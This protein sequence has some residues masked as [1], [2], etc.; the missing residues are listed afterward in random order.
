MTQREKDL[1]YEVLELL[2]KEVRA[3]SDFRNRDWKDADDY[4][5]SALHLT[6]GDIAEIYSGRRGLVYDKSAIEGF[7]PV[8]PSYAELLRLHAA[9]AVGSV[10]LECELYKSALN[11]MPCIRAY[12]ID[13]GLVQLVLTSADA[14]TTGG[15]LRG[16]YYTVLPA[17]KAV[18]GCPRSASSVQRQMDMWYY[19]LQRKNDKFT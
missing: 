5:F 15:I 6:Q 8:C 18:E 10:T 4:I 3:S 17:G 11:D 19:I 9:Y 2:R 12:S 16:A 14:P 7:Y 1:F 13:E